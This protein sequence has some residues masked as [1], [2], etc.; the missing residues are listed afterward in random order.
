MEGL[1]L[2]SLQGSCSRTEKAWSSPGLS[3]EAMEGVLKDRLFELLFGRNG[4]A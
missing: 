4:E 1:I 3:G 2:G